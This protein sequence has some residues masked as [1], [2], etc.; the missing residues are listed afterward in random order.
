MPREAPVI[1]IFEG[2]FGGLGMYEIVIEVV[3]V[4]MVLGFDGFSPF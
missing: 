3:S 2:I 4:S 1:R